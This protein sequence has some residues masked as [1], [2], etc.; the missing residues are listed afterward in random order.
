MEMVWIVMEPR[1]GIAIDGSTLW[2]DIKNK[3][4]ETQAN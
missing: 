1:V 3:A 2:V 4:G